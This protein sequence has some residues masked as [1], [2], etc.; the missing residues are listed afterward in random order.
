MRLKTVHCG[1]HSD[2]E[3]QNIPEFGTDHREGPVPSGFK[4]RLRHHKLGL[5]LRPQSA[6]WNVNLE[7]VGDVLRG[8]SIQSFKN[9]QKDLKINSKINRE[10]VQG[11]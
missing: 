4:S 7:A 6:R 10:P 9:K 11:S 5:A 2:V 8:Q 1:G 3:G